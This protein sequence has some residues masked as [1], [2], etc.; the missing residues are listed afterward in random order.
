M[1]E[2]EYQSRINFYFLGWLTE[3]VRYGLGALS[4]DPGRN[5]YVD[6]ESEIEKFG[7]NFYY[8][9]LPKDSLFATQYKRLLE[10]TQLKDIKAV[11]RKIMS[12]IEETALPPFDPDKEWQ[13]F[14]QS[15]ST[16]Q[17]AYNLKQMLGLPQNSAVGRLG[18][19][20]LDFSSASPMS[21]IIFKKTTFNQHKLS[22][23]HI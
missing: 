3:A 13:N 16:L 21:E 8:E 10:N 15:N 18:G 9:Q 19:G 1:Y 7:V 11:N 14:L 4:S 22:L 2:T 6:D 17:L 12:Y 5:A 23:I 20:Q